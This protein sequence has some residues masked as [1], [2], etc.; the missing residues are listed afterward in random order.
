MRATPS[1]VEQQHE[2]N[3]HDRAYVDSVTIGNR[4][5]LGLHGEAWETSVRKSPDGFNRGRFCCNRFC[6]NRLRRNRLHGV[7]LNAVDGGAQ[8]RLFLLAKIT[9]GGRFGF[10]PTR[11]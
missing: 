6:R 11:G 5:R 7:V 8:L 10:A 3:R 1:H 2:K 4:L 9:N